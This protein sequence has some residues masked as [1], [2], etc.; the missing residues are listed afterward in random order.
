VFGDG[1]GPESLLVVAVSHL[2]NGDRPSLSGSK[3]TSCGHRH[4]AIVAE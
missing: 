3:M 2:E 4:A 1:K